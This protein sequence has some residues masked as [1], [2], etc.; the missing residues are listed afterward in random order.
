MLVSLSI[1]IRERFLHLHRVADI[2]SYLQTII[3]EN[4]LQMTCFP[5]IL[6]IANEMV[7]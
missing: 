6:L 2:I 3:I 7:S 1:S 5:N 4:S